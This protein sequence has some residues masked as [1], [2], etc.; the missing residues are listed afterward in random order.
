MTAIAVDDMF[1]EQDFRKLGTVTLTTTPLGWEILGVHKTR[2]FRGQPA[3]Y[4]FEVARCDCVEKAQAEYDE[5][6]RKGGY[7]AS[8]TSRPLLVCAQPPGHSA[9]KAHKREYAHCDSLGH[10][11]K[12]RALFEQVAKSYDKAPKLGPDLKPKAVRL[13]ANEHERREYLEWLA[14]NAPDADDP[15]A[16]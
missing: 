9:V 1:V 8:C 11:E 16:R 10:E 15:Y 3:V 6:V 2:T 7:A 5:K 13:T 14:D 12:V 4:R